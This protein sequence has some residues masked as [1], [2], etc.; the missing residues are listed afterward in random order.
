MKVVEVVP[1]SARANGIL[2]AEEV[3]FHLS[4]A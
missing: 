3:M 4:F 2:K 1:T